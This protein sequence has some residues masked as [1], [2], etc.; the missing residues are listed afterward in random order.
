MRSRTSRSFGATSGSS[1]SLPASA[2]LRPLHST[3][4]SAACLCDN[5]PT[6]Q[7]CQRGHMHLQSTLQVSVILLRCRPLQWHHCSHAEW[8]FRSRDCYCPRAAHH[9]KTETA[10]AAVTAGCCTKGLSHSQQQVLPRLHVTGNCLTTI[11]YFDASEA[12]RVLSQLQVGS[13]QQRGQVLEV[14]AITNVVKSVSNEHG[15]AKQ[16]ALLVLLD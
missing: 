5:R 12:F 4:V 8:C 16:I 11:A 7:L 14:G 9:H 10:A 3:R 15:K 6:Q 1:D 13:T 2:S